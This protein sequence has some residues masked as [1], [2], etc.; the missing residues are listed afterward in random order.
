[1]CVRHGHSHL[2]CLLYKSL[3]RRHDIAKVAA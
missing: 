3:M 1:M 2:A